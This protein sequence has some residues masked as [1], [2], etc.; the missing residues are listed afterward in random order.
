LSLRAEQTNNLLQ[1][2]MMMQQQQDVFRPL[3]SKGRVVFNPATA[4]YNL[5]EETETK[6][7]LRESQA[8]WDEEQVLLASP[9]TD[10]SNV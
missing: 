4:R 2:L 1:Q 3:G 8:Q 9:Y 6:E 7:G 5:L 10:S